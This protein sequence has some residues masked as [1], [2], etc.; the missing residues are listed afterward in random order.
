MGP[1]LQRVFNPNHLH[2][3]I[4]DMGPYLQ[5]VFNPKCLHYAILYVGLYLLY[6]LNPNCLHCTIHDMGVISTVYF[7]SKMPPQCHLL[8]SS[9]YITI[10]KPTAVQLLTTINGFTDC[11]KWHS[12]RSF[13]L[14]THCRYGP[15][16]QMEQWRHFEL[17]TPCRYGPM[18]QMEQ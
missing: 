6:I 8:I 14:K 16:L 2:C 13:G 4:C 15:I 18:S 1:Y 9:Y 17:K 10:F 5:F 12:G 3:T 7:Q 11:Y